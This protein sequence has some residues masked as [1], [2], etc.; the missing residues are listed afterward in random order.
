MIFAVALAALQTPSVNPMLGD[1]ARWWWIA[2]TTESAIYVDNHTIERSGN[3][4][5][6]WVETVLFEDHQELTSLDNYEI[7]CGQR[8]YAIRTSVVF[9][10]RELPDGRA[11]SEGRYSLAPINEGTL[12]ALVA[13]FACPMAAQRQMIAI[14]MHVSNERATRAIQRL[15]NLNVGSAA[16][17]VVASL[18]PSPGIDGARALFVIASF[19]DDPDVRVA[20][21]RIIGI[22]AVADVEP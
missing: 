2:S 12:A 14:P 6:V 9:S 5:S 17:A 11:L 1:P 15:L 18:D 4:R 10:R 20:A 21:G 3:R 16:A 13:D 19:V 8:A 22:P 7:D